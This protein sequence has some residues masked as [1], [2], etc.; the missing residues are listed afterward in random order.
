[1]SLKIA[2]FTFNTEAQI[3]CC[4][5]NKKQSCSLGR[6][7]L[8][9]VTTDCVAS[10]FVEAFVKHI[11]EQNNGFL[12]DIFIIGLQESSINNPK[13]KFVSDQLLFAFYNCIKKKNDNYVFIREKM[14]GIGAEGI[15][16]LRI[17]AIIGEGFKFSYKFLLYRPLIE[18][19]H[20]SASEGQQFG[21]GAMLLDL[22]MEK[23]NN[24]YRLN[25]INTHLPFLPKY[26]DQ[27]KEI[28]NET[29]I[30]TIDSFET[31]LGETNSNKFLMGDLNYRVDFENI[32]KIKQQEY[33]Q[34]FKSNQISKTDV[35]NFK[36]HDQLTKI[37][38]NYEKLQKYK[39]G[40]NNSGPNFLP[41][42]KLLKNCEQKT[43]QRKYQ[44]GKDK[45]IRLPSWC[46][47]ILYDGDIECLYYD[48]FDHGSTCKSDH[49]PVIGL[50]EIKPT[51]DGVTKTETQTSIIEDPIEI[52][53][54]IETDAKIETPS[55]PIETEIKIET[56]DQPKAPAEIKLIEQAGGDIYYP[57]Y[58]KYKQKYVHLKKI[59]NKN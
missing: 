45:T 43:A 42:C 29:L 6:Q 30:E 5:C 44:M 23:D 1:M 26:P 8:K 32:N 3:F 54:P 16:G 59:V 22:D 38:K 2:I 14:R 31:K 10:D 17:G 39:E 53:N 20:V 49:I 47:R 40:A 25:F 12:P 13:K 58:L 37:I 48:N 56:P 33:L 11:Q 55:K 52:D 24:N 28:R 7:L 34:L 27:G 9:Y 51:V 21:K 35:I 46:D 19:I 36:E 18:S 4:S 57:K 15:R 41:T 50:Y